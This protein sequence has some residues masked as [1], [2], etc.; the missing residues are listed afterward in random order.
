MDLVFVVIV[1]N[2]GTAV[3]LYLE[4]KGAVLENLA[5]PF[6]EGGSI[7]TFTAVYVHTRSGRCVHAC[8]CAFRCLCEHVPV[9]LCLFV[10]V[11]RPYLSV[12]ARFCDAAA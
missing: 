2:L 9:C 4:I 7:S 1:S 3:K 6:E 5:V 8:Q 11:L 10:S 12:C